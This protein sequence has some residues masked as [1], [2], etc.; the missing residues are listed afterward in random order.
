MSPVDEAPVRLQV[1]ITVPR[2]AR[3]DEQG[4]VILALDLS[5]RTNEVLE[6]LA[7]AIDS[8]KGEAIRRALGLFKLAVEAHGEGKRIGIATADQ[9]LDTEIEIF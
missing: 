8:D 5:E 9:E 6:Q 4:R 2:Q 1:G 7:R 3:V